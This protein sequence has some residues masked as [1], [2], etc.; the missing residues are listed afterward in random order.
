MPRLG[1]GRGA[2]LG[3]PQGACMQATG[4]QRPGTSRPDGNPCPR[5]LFPG[6]RQVSPVSLASPQG[7]PPRTLVGKT[8]LACLVCTLAK[9]MCFRRSYSH[10]VLGFADGWFLAC[11]ARE[12]IGSVVGG[13]AVHAGGAS[14][15]AGPATGAPPC[16]RV[17]RA[18]WPSRPLPSGSAGRID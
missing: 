2:W 12:D 18:R 6:R 5:P 4:G 7:W 16:D 13:T 9:S 3:W 10:S 17:P 1:V 14:P 15:G 11:V 8:A